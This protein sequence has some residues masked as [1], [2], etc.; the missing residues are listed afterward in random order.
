MTEP[1]RPLLEGSSAVRAAEAVD[2]IAADLERPPPASDRDDAGDL[3]RRVDEASLARGR[4]GYALF[5]GCK[6]A[7]GDEDAAASCLTHLGEA[8]DALAHVRMGPSLF[9][10]F[11][12]VAWACE[13]LGELGIVDTEE[14]PNEAI[15]DVVLPLLESG[16]IEEVDLISGVVGVG[17]YALQRLPRPEARKSLESVVARLEERAVAAAEGVAWPTPPDALPVDT[18]GDYP[19]GYYNLGMAHGSAGVIA[20]LAG[21]VNAGVATARAAPLLEQAVRW[22]LAQETEDDPRSLFPAIVDPRGRTEASR[23]AWCYG[24]PGTAA[25]LGL[26]AAAGDG[27]WM[28]HARRV[29][30]AAARR[31]EEMCGVRDACLCHGAAGL[32]HV[33]NRLAVQLDDDEIAAAARVWF[34]RALDMRDPGEGVGGFRTYRAGRDIEARW[35]DHPGM[36]AGAAGVGLALLA[37]TGD[38]PPV[39]DRPFLLSIPHRRL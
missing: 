22:L 35:I 1:W 24:D 18:R 31:P 21:A 11:C 27:A 4:A 6:A 38:A 2:A 5:F 13:V 37:A 14:D 29:A 9:M 16:S 30:L 39:W 33:L 34:E 3:Q 23:T 12:G 8:I 36:L 26:A 17:V 10:G 15:D 25:A 32:A 28:G 20:L 7:A 19:E